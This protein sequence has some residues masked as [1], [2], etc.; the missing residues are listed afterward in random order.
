MNSLFLRSVVLKRD[1]VENP[2]RYPFSL[3]VVRYLDKLDLHEPVTFFVGENGTG[4][5]TLLEAIAI[6]YGFNPEGGSKNFQFSTYSSHS[7]LSEALALWKGV[8]TPTDGF[9]LRAESFYNV[10]SE[11]DAM[12]LQK[13]YGGKSLHAQS[14][15]ESFLSL[16]LHR[17]RGNGL[18]LLD[19]P[20]AALSPSRQLAL[21]ARIHD[22][23][24]QGSQFLIATHSPIVLG[25][26]G[27][28]IYAFEEDGL[29]RTSY[30][31][32]EHYQLTKAFLNNPAAILR[33]LFAE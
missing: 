18:Y 21:L 23:V 26:P 4:K 20:E 2:H 25:Y 22:L 31:E 7:E 1:K 24:E 9:F 16:L 32:T 15:G 19:E 17:F 5:S 3:P 13:S 11:V 33:E 6:Q 10:A 29:R 8:R 27:A 12:G 28:A 14:H 30:E